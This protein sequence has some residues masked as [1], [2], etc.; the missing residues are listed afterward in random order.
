MFNEQIDDETWL[1]RALPI[2]RVSPDQTLTR[3][4]LRVVALYRDALIIAFLAKKSVIPNEIFHPTEG[5][6]ALLGLSQLAAPNRFLLSDIKA[7]RVKEPGL[8]VGH[9]FILEFAGGKVF[10]FSTEREG[11]PHLVSALAR[12][13]GNRFVAPRELPDWTLCYT[14]RALTRGGVVPPPVNFLRDPIDTIRAAWKVVKA[15]VML[16]PRI[17]CRIL[18]R[19]RKSSR[20]KSYAQPKTVQR[21]PHRSKKRGA[22]FIGIGLLLMLLQ[23][24]YLVLGLV[25]L[26]STAIRP[27]LLIPLLPEQIFSTLGGVLI[28]KVMGKPG[29]ELVSALLVNAALA[30]GS[31]FAGAWFFGRGKRMRLPS[32]QES[33]DKDKRPPIL[34]LRSFMDEDIAL[35]K[36]EESRTINPALW[37]Y[38]PILL[39]LLLSRFIRFLMGRET[40]RVEEHLAWFFGMRGP[41]VAIGKPGDRI[42]TPG[43]ARAYLEKEDWRVFVDELLVRSQTVILQIQLSEGT[44]WE[45]SECIGRVQPARLLLV[46][47][48]LRGSQQLYEELRIHAW[49]ILPVPLPPNLDGA[50]FIR[51][52]ADWTPH[53]MKAK[54]HTWLTRMIHLSVIDLKASLRPFLA[55]Q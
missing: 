45:F 40:T 21:R 19:F 32:L 48:A 27:W 42:V 31:L 7:V 34:F 22:L 49:N 9:C 36:E 47:A 39:M 54:Y 11:I 10:S 38:F 52:D 28:A 18:G 35:A 23:V 51:F 44:W 46:L 26:A 29:I 1:E 13:L 16:A 53:L 6:A 14:E 5:S 2:I 12:L 43:A 50:D 4:G 15:G 55:G 17:V 33:L 25:V 24:Y 3:A 30:I 8:F 41:V 37:Q 20:Q